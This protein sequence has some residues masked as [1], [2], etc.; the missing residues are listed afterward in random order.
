MAKK[1]GKDPYEVEPKPPVI[2]H[3]V[4]RRIQQQ[5]AF[6]GVPAGRHGPI[7]KRKRSKNCVEPPSPVKPEHRR[8][9]RGVPIKG[10]VN[11]FGS[12]DFKPEPPT[13]RVDRDELPNDVIVRFEGDPR[14]HD[15]R[16]FV[17]AT[18]LWIGRVRRETCDTEKLVT[19][20]RATNG[21]FSEMF[22]SRLIAAYEL[23]QRFGDKGGVA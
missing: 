9:G 6:G 8:V 4:G 3:I 19:A 5:R 17:D 2:S 10:G 13:H 14:S 23:W 12:P 16:V 7:A 22:A 21:E 20:W 1:D 11:T 15:Y 18:D